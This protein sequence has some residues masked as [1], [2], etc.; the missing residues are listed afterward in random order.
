MKKEGTNSV[1]Q[2]CGAIYYKPPSGRGK[3][4][5]RACTHKSLSRNYS[6]ELSETIWKF[7]D[8]TN[9]DAAC[10]IWNGATVAGGYGCIRS[11]GKLH[12]AHRAVYEL[13]VGPIPN[14][15][16]LLH[17]CDNPKCCNPKHLRPG[18]AKENLHDAISRNRFL[19]GE[20]SPHSKLSNEDVIAIRKER[21]TGA[22]G[23]SLSKKYGI[24]ESE[25]S[26]IVNR[27]RWTHV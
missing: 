4:C 9:G 15:A 27:R 6:K 10:W 5:S 1:C 14:G 7:I 13:L 22:T 21:A 11:K 25:I 18:N 2:E 17:S 20:K 24:A 3:F 26:A 23:R 19:V 8:R 16:F 12:R